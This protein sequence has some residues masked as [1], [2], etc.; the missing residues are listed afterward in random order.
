M[1]RLLKIHTHYPAYLESYYR[2]NPN[3]VSKTY[4][5]QKAELD[6]DAVAWA[7]Y[8]SKALKP[9]GYEVME[10]CSNAVPMQRAWLMENAPHLGLDPETQPIEVVNEQLKQFQPDLLLVENYSDFGKKWLSVARQLAPIRL[11]MVA[12]GAP[13]DGHEADLAAYDLILSCIPEL[14]TAFRSQGS[15]SELLPHAFES[16]VANRLQPRKIEHDLTFLGQIVRGKKQHEERETYLEHLVQ[17]V[18]IEIFSPMYSWSTLDEVKL[19]AKRFLYDSLPRTPVLSLIPKIGPKLEKLVH[20]PLPPGGGVSPTLKPQM[21]AG[22]F[23]LKM[24]QTLRNSLA[25]FNLHID[26]SKNSA[27]N[28]RLFEATGAGTCLLTDHKATL[29]DYFKPDVEVVTYRSPE[30][31]AEKARWLIAHPEKA[32]EIALAGQRRTLS[33]HN[34][35]NRAVLLN[36]LIRERI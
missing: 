28:M 9:H 14:V 11:A 24:F 3:T 33:E 6:W 20:A 2:E 23:G 10:V 25:T 13:Y 27:S 4:D 22:M 29:S 8:W 19:R 1:L 35:T 15:K 21:R 32:A 17:S 34:F 7:D 18:G 36:R 31:C 12:C 16:E 5:E 30:E 26:L